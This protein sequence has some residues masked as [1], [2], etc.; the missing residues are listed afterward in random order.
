[1]R[2]HLRRRFASRSVGGKLRS[3][4]GEIMP[5]G[6]A[7]RS[8]AN[9]GQ[10]LHQPMHQR[11]AQERAV[12]HRRAGAIGRAASSSA[13]LDG[14]IGA[15]RDAAA[16][17]CA[18]ARPAARSCAV[19]LVRRRCVCRGVVRHLAKAQHLAVAVVGRLADAMRRSARRATSSYQQPSGVS[20]HAFVAAHHQPLGGARHRHIEQAAIFVARFAAAP[21]ARASPSAPTSLPCAPA[22]TR[23]SGA[24]GGA[25]GGSCSS[26]GGCAARR[27]R[28]G[29]GED[30]D[31]RLKALGAVHGHHPH[32]VARHLHVA[33]HLGCGGAQPGDEA[34]QRRRLAR[35][36][37]R[38]RD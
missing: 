21:C 10:R 5:R 26:R 15:R 31:R 28:R 22:Q 35:A 37:S 25:S 12:A 9:I 23:R 18:S 1:M 33:L 19:A 38:A 32:L 17:A 36:H 29:V 6:S 3:C 24:P 34:L 14:V 2:Q 13:K 16:G 20:L 8:G 30:D 4:A 27:R 7:R 11:A